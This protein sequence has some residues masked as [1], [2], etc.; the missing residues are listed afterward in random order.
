VFGTDYSIEGISTVPFTLT[1]PTTS[2]GSS[3]AITPIDNANVDSERTLTFTLASVTGGLQIGTSIETVVTIVDDEVPPTPT[4]DFSNATATISEDGGTL[5]VDFSLS[6]TTTENASVEITVNG[7][8]SATL[9]NDFDIEGQSTSPYALDVTSGSSTASLNI[10]ISDDSDSE[11]DETIVLAIT[12][13]TGGLQV[14]ST[15]QQQTITITDNDA[16]VVT[17]LTIPYLETFEAYDGTETY[18]TNILGYQTTIAGQTID[19]TV[20]PIVV[21]A[22]G[23]F[24]DENDNTASSDP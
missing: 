5:T 19:P 18:L 22:S 4:I 17:G 1:V 21:N 7:S 14:G 8:G 16:A 12:G 15:T 23:T 10:N 24:S 9:G 3:F 20:L 11:A 13:A 2:T 6:A